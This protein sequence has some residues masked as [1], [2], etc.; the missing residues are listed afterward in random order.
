MKNIN[1]ST[2]V[3][4]LCLLFVSSITFAFQFTLPGEDPGGGNG[5]GI[6]TPINFLVYLGMAVGAFFGYNKLKK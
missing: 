1:K 4:T 3:L 6:D 5:T 2:L